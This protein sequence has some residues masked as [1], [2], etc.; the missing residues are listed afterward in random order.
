MLFILIRSDFHWGSIIIFDFVS[1][2]MLLN[3][4]PVLTVERVKRRH[5]QSRKYISIIIFDFVSYLM[6]LN[7]LPVLTVER[8]RV[9]RRHWHSHSRKYI[10]II[11]F[12]FVS[13][14][15]LLNPLLHTTW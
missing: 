7:A 5:G 6:L 14:L 9:K 11:I 4:L 3:A 1:Y 13:Y 10:S 2:L 15:M 8:V 12:D